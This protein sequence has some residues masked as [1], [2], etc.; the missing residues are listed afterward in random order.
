MPSKPPLAFTSSIAII[1]PFIIDV[2][3]AAAGPLSIVGAPI[4]I[5]STSSGGGVGS[6]AG[7]TG[8]AGSAALGKQPLSVGMTSTKAR[9]S[10]TGTTNLRSLFLFI[11]SHSLKFFGFSEA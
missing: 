7:A 9:I 2:P 11:K 10:E 4:I 8:A 6:G 3:S 1:I 5:G